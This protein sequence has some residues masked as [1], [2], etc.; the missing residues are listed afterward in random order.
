MI[1]KTGD[2]PFCITVCQE[3]NYVYMQLFTQHSGPNGDRVNIYIHDEETDNSGKCEYKYTALVEALS[4]S[5]RAMP[6]EAIDSFIEELRVGQEVAKELERRFFCNWQQEIK[7]A[8]GLMPPEP[9]E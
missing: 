9:S 1:G 6:L 2:F 4:P 3:S 5:G 7:T 8:M